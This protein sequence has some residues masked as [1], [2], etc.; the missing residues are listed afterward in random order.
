MSH[1]SRDLS[2]RRLLK[3]L[4]GGATTSVSGS[5]DDTVINPD[6]S[7]H[8]SGLHFHLVRP[9]PFDCPCHSSRFARD[10]AVP[11]GPANVPLLSYKVTTENGTV[12]VDTRTTIP[13]SQVAV[14]P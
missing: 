4:A 1:P 6:G 13:T 3:V 12:H 8:A 5:G 2:R 11:Q 14:V 7:L 10:R 9:V